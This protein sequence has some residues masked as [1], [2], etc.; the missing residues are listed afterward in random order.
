MAD[1]VLHWGVTDDE[2]YT[3]VQLQQGRKAL[4]QTWLEPDTNPDQAVRRLIEDGVL[5]MGDT[6]SHQGQVPRGK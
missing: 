5:S 2:G 3:L 1:Y 6:V 4:T